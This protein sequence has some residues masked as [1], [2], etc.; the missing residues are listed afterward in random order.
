[1]PLNKNDKP[2]VWPVVLRLGIG[3][4]LMAGPIIGCDD[5]AYYPYYGFGGGAASSSGSFGSSTS[6]SLGEN[7]VDLCDSVT[8]GAD[9]YSGRIATSCERGDSANANCNPHLV[10]ST[11]GLW[12]TEA[13]QRAVCAP[14]TACP[15]SYTET[16]PDA[17]CKRPDAKSLLCEYDEGLCGCA[18][19]GGLDRGTSGTIP[20]KKDAG[21]KDSGSDSGHALD[22]GAPPSD[23]GTRTYEWKCVHADRDAGC[24]RRRPREGI[25]CVRPLNCDYGY[26]AFED[27]FRMDCYSGNWVRDTSRSELCDQ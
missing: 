17:L 18:P 8:E 23:A 21:A 24:P 26:C 10:C 5:D 2:R 1:M 25:E 22:A 16:V 19:V 20:T 7:H 12:T 11:K 15:T 14:T 27:G 13:P 4:A 3:L 6:G 9:C